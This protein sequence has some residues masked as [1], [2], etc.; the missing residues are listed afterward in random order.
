MEF[1]ANAALI[2]KEGAR[3]GVV[4]T[5]ITIY[6]KIVTTPRSIPFTNAFLAP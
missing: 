6:A 3:L 1:I 4:I 5:M 2:A